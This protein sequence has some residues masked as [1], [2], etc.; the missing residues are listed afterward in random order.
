MRITFLLGNGFDLN[1]KLKTSYNDFIE[2]Y[3][4]IQEDDRD[5]EF[6]KNHIKRNLTLWSQ[7]EEALGNYTEK[8]CTN[9]SQMETFLKCHKDFSEKLA[10]YLQEEMQRFLECIRDI[11][12]EMYFGYALSKVTKG[13]HKSED[14]FL[15]KIDSRNK[16]QDIYNFINFNYTDTLKKCYEVTKMNP[17]FRKK[18]GEL[19]HIHGDTYSN[20]LFGVNDET[21]IANRFLFSECKEDYI[22]QIIKPKNNELFRAEVLKKAINIL[23]ESDVIYLYGTSMGITDLVWW[24]YLYQLLLHNEMLHVIVYCH[25]APEESRINAEYYR[26]LRQRKEEFLKYCEY[27]PYVKERLMNQIHITTEN[28]FKRFSDIVPN[29]E[30]TSMT[31]TAKSEVIKK[32]IRQ[33]KCIL[34]LDDD[35]EFEFL[36]T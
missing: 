24:E 4:M 15:E 34:E 27:E 2:E 7:A 31:I 13:V 35:M 1:L 28:I 3:K 20:M 17:Q 22:A 6:F 32:G 23:H 30:K 25:N 5:I 12:I 36:D 11:D 33:S 26:F 21:Q 8:F 10:D 18:M 16:D 14:K 9:D 29:E 19:I